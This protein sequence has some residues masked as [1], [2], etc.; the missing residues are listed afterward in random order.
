MLFKTR[1]NCV[2][3]N[4]QMWHS[5]TLHLDRKP[6]LS[7]TP[8][9]RFTLPLAGMVAVSLFF[10]PAASAAIRTT[11]REDG[12]GEAEGR[13]PCT[14]TASAVAECHAACQREASLYAYNNNYIQSIIILPA[15]HGGPPRALRVPPPWQGPPLATPRSENKFRFRSPHPRSAMMRIMMHS[16]RCPFTAARVYY[17]NVNQLYR[18]V[19]FY[20]IYAYALAQY[21]YLP[22]YLPT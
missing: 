6:P 12:G 10:C 20:H 7:C 11:T 19:S 5:C 21:S 14:T 3:S 15:R 1:R 22:T 16:A 17:G 4:V 8:P 9:P 2:H 13:N 18:G